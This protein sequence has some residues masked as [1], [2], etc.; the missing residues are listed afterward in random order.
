MELLHRLTQLG[1]PLGRLRTVNRLHLTPRL[2]QVQDDFAEA[3]ESIDLGKPLPPL[4][5]LV[6]RL[7][8][9]VL[10]EQVIHLACAV[11]CLEVEPLEPLEPLLLQLFGAIPPRGRGRK[12]KRLLDILLIGGV[13]PNQLGQVLRG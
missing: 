6:E 2:L 11:K 8:D 13:F 12:F 3:D 5:N 10:Q 9:L 7:L 1:K 4:G